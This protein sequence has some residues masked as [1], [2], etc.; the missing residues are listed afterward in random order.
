V[1]YRILLEIRV[2]I[3]SVKR[4]LLLLA[5]AAALLAAAP[6]TEA[7]PRR[8]PLGFYG[9]MW[10]RAAASA[11][12]ADQAAQWDLMARSGVE[13]VRTVFSWA[14]AQPEGGQ[15]PSF[16]ATDQVVALAAARKIRLLPIVV[17]TPA[18][19][20]R[21]P[22]AGRASPPARIEDYTAYLQ[23]LVQRYG[24]K[25]SFWAER[26]DLPRRPLREWQIWNEP[27]LDAYWHVTGDDPTAW[28]PEYVA[29]LRESKRAIEAVDPSATIVLASLADASWKLLTRLYRAG[30]R[31]NFD[32]VGINIFTARPGF[33]MAAAR[34]VRRVLR[35]EH[36][37]RMPMWVTETTFPAGEGRVSRPPLSW[38]Q[39]WYTT[40]IGMAHRLRQLYRLGR[41]NHRRLRL[42]RIYWYTWASAYDGQDDLFEYAG[43]TQYGP[44]LT[45]RP[46]LATYARSA[47]RA[48]GCRKTAAGACG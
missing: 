42:A 17:G 40:D 34:L 11:P 22:G 8:V 5:L 27:H 9:V 10:D 32:V 44:S 43:L 45:P 18:W 30:A 1:V 14:K 26:P 16:A 4:G 46:A 33:V 47:R 15:P 23:A 37:P 25:G 38:Q 36:Q 41:R 3:H 28:A 31:G 13:S 6:A 7:S 48:E 29:L 24:P 20:A 2:S 39:N 12:E 35:R 19:A 21:D